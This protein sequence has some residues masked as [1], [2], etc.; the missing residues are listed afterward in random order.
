MTGALAGDKEVRERPEGS[1]H[2]IRIPQARVD[3]Q[4]PIA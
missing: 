1:H 3:L 4:L 2:R